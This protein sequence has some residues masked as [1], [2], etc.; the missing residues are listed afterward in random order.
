MPIAVSRPGVLTKGGEMLII[1][2]TIA[3]LAP[4]IIITFAVLRQRRFQQLAA[5][6]ALRNHLSLHN[7]DA[8]EL[9]EDSPEALQQ[10]NGTLQRLT[11]HVLG[12]DPGYIL[13]REA[14]YDLITV[15]IAAVQR[16]RS[17]S[18]GFGSIT[19]YEREDSST[20]VEYHYIVRTGVADGKA[21]RAKLKKKAEGTFS[22]ASVAW[23]GGE[24]AA[25]L[26]SQK[27]LNMAV[28]ST[29]MP[30]DDLKVVYD[31]KHKV[32]RIVLTMR[33]ENRQRFV[34]GFSH[35]EVDQSFPLPSAEKMSVINQIAGLVRQGSSGSSPP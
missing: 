30:Q 19:V 25:L 5:L 2:V 14:N 29:L 1:I 12:D 15:R 24:L 7:I 34:M 16:T 35:S 32:A 11:R 27:E 9:P 17:T 22:I 23:R 13:V 3:I 4:L 20:P 28:K 33:K 10:D 6:N 18:F 21:L 31:R 8:S 26:N